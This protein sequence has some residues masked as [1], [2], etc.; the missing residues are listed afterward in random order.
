M[1]ARC[2]GIYQYKAQFRAGGAHLDWAPPQP[3]P[4]Y[5]GPAELLG[6]LCTAWGVK[7][8]V[9]L[10]SLQPWAPCVLGLP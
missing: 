5:C 3:T 7:V 8:P 9:G 4:G 1:P 6:A 2:A 10:S